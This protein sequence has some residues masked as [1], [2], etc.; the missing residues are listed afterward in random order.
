MWLHGISAR[1]TIRY[2]WSK[3]VSNHSYSLSIVPCI[4]ATK[5]RYLQ[6][7][8]NAAETANAN[9]RFS[10]TLD[11][12]PGN[13]VER[14]YASPMAKQL[15]ITFTGISFLPRLQIAFPSGVTD[16]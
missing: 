4:K 12:I 1:D 7:S 14:Q 8:E 5:S 11:A 15:Q 16:S 2:Q 6:L 10:S 9:S 3:G 13:L